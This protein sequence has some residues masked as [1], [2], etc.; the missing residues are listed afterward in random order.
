MVNNQNS[1][2]ITYSKHAVCD[3]QTAQSRGFL[4]LSAAAA[5]RGNKDG[6]LSPRLEP[7]AHSMILFPSGFAGAL[8]LRP[9]D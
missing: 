3:V 2:Y 6:T 5:F 4:N 7:S 1:L 8:R 9:P